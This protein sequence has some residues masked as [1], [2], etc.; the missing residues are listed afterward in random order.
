MSST[1]GIRLRYA[2]LITYFEED[3]RGFKWECCFETGGH[4]VVHQ[5]RET[6]GDGSLKR[7]FVAKFGVSN[8]F[9][10]GTSKE[11]AMAKRLY[12]AFHSVQAIV[13]YQSMRNIDSI[14]PPGFDDRWNEFPLFLRFALL[15]EY[16]S[17]AT[18][19][20][21]CERAMTRAESIPN[22][23][24]WTIFGCLVRMICGWAQPPDRPYGNE[25]ELPSLEPVPATERVSANY[26]IYH[27]D[28]HRENMIFGDMDIGEHAL[29]P[30]LKAIDFGFA[31]DNEDEV[32]YKR[33]WQEQARA[34]I[35]QANIYEIGAIIKGVYEEYVDEENLDGD[36]YT[37]AELCTDHDPRNRPTLGYLFYLVFRA[38]ASKTGPEHFA[39]K[40]YAQWESDEKIRELVKDTIF[41]PSRTSDGPFLYAV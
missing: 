9:L 2:R 12:G 41:S 25:T 30:L 33:G 23:V 15:L 39:T 13:D 20:S 38:I 26:Q 35:T 40:K 1:K 6:N 4:G 17:N 21:F 24:L 3:S 7:R 36:L 5:L 27:G 31:L 29:V 11:S 8:D 18:L 19:E 37:L 10:D 16:V 32:N 28:L 14:P 34:T 22:R